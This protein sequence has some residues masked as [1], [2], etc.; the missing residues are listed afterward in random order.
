MYVY[1]IYTGKVK[2]WGGV[3]EVV[4]KGLKFYFLPQSPRGA[5]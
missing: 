2:L 3:V 1:K 5:G 4:H